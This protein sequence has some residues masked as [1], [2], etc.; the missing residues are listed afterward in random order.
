[1]KSPGLNSNQ[2]LILEL[3]RDVP[4]LFTPELARAAAGWDLFLA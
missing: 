3:I 2:K 1:M 4:D